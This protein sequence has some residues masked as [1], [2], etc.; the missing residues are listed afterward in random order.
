LRA[1][2]ARVRNKKTACVLALR[3]AYCAFAPVSLPKSMQKD[4]NCGMSVV[5]MPR[6]GAMLIYKAPVT[7][8]LFLL[9]DVLDIKSYGQLPGFGD[10]SGEVLAQ[11]LGEGARFY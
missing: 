2:E 11:I 1:A 5:A 8:T 7:E 6:E 10:A 4:E 9:E 3:L